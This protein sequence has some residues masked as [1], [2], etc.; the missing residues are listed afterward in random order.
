[1]QTF[2]ELS[3]IGILNKSYWLHIVVGTMRYRSQEIF[4]QISRFVWIEGCCVICV[5]LSQYCRQFS[6]FAVGAISSM[7]ELQ[8]FE[9]KYKNGQWNSPILAET[10]FQLKR[11]KFTTQHL[12]FIK[13]HNINFKLMMRF[14]YSISFN[15]RSYK[16]GWRCFTA[17]GPTTNW[18]SGKHWYCSLGCRRKK[19]RVARSQSWS[20]LP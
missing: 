18:T 15:S 12:P 8:G 16:A 7:F 14:Y 1:M 19:S 10:S 13:Q 6:L 20:T 11:S 9:C 5:L 17:R 4:Y 3:R 2:S